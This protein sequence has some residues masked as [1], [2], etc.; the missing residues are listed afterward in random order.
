MKMHL[1]LLALF[2]LLASACS[3]DDA[4]QPS[5]NLLHY[6][7]P[8]Q[9]GPVLDAGFYEAAARFPATE[10]AR[11]EGAQ[12]VA[13]RWFMG[14]AP[15]GC[16][17]RVYGPGPAGRPGTSLYMANVTADVEEFAWNEHTLTV[18]VDIEAEELWI[19]IAFTHSQTQQSIGCDT[20]PNDPNGDW[21]FRSVA[22]NWQRY[23]AFTPERVNWNIRGVVE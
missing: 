6:D 1:T 21:L 20:G 17:V 9:T 7:G 22:N 2:L 11:F 12:L 18:P 5:D 13:V 16:E 10:T 15:A 19:S 23:S 8:N 3:D 4:A 14:P